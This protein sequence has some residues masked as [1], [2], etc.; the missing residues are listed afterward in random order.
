MKTKAMTSCAD[1]MSVW[2]NKD[3]HKI[4]RKDAAETG[5]TISELATLAIQSY[6][7]SITREEMERNK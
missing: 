6:Y 5:A 2:I 3:V 4:L 7:R 1:K